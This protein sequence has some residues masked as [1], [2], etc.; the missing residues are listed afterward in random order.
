MPAG[1]SLAKLRPGILEIMEAYV[2]PL[3]D[4]IGIVCTLAAATVISLAMALDFRGWLTKYADRMAEQYR[5]PVYKL[6]L[7]TPSARRWHQDPVLLR[8][9]FR[10]MAVATLTVF[11]PLLLVE[12][13]ILAI[14]GVR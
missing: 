8:R 3:G 12:I 2:Q 10:V 4:A 5:R 9:S 7:L 6:F 13:V 14:R 11:G 1:R